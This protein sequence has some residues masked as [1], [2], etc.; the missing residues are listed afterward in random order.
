MPAIDD[1]PGFTGCA[2]A[3]GNG[4]A[5]RQIKLMEPA[6]VPARIATGRASGPSGGR[7]VGMFSDRMGF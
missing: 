2:D 7:D 6:S 4:T 3:D 5:G 1:R